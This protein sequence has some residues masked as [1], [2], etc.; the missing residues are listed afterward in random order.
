MAENTE[1]TSDAGPPA[2][3]VGHCSAGVGRSRGKLTRRDIVQAAVKII[4][5]GGLPSLT[6]RK[7]SSQLQVQPT[8]LAR[9]F[10]NRDELLDA[11]ADSIID[12][13]PVDPDLPADT[14]LWQDYL[15]HAAHT[16]RRA[17]LAHPAVFPLVATRPLA[18]PGLQPPLRSLQWT[19][20]FL[21]TLHRCGFSDTAAVAAYRA[22]GSFLL[23]QL[24]PEV[25]T[26]GAALGPGGHADPRPPQAVDLAGDP[27][28][29]R[30]KTALLHCDADA[31][32]EESL[33]SLLDRLETRGIR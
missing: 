27:R 28:L 25:T 32:F 1:Q 10:G 8:S 31:E 15:Q 26:L 20:N 29:H 30:M 14:C 6:M 22:F 33:E 23:G 9:M 13:L 21:D 2:P 7:I 3:G 12:E 18:T 16:V 11:I 5:R 17:A 4:D 19:E 24:L